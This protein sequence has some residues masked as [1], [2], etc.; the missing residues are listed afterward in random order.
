VKGPT[1][2]L[3]FDSTV[4]VNN[5]ISGTGAL[6]KN[7][8]GTLVVNAIRVATLSFGGGAIKLN[9]DGGPNGVSRATALSVGGKLDLN[10]NSI[11]VDYDPA[12]NLTAFQDLRSAIIAGRNGGD[13]KGGSGITS[14]LAAAKV[15]SQHPTAIGYGDAAALGIG[16][17]NGQT[18]TDNSVVIAS[19]TLAGDANLDGV[20]NALDF[21]AV[22][23][24]FGAVSPVWTQGDFDFDNDVSTS[25]FTVMAQNFGLTTAGAGGASLGSV[26]PEPATLLIAPALALLRRRRGFIGR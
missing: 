6:T 23:T 7:G 9:P 5:T 3:D 18:F 19:Y 14:A 21:N 13:W 11:V 4:N 24:N 20:V 22:A 1:G 10:N 25:D 2:F 12:L 26:V 16:S 8:S 17:F 15:G